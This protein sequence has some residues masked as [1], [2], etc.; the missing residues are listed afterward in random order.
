MS[1]LAFQIFRFYLRYII[2]PPA[3]SGTPNPSNVLTAVNFLSEG[4]APFTYEYQWIRSG[5][6][7]AG[8][9]SSTYTVTNQDSLNE[10]RVGVRSIDAQGRKSFWGYSDPVSV[11]VVGPTYSVQPTFDNPTYTQ[12]S[13]ITVTTG[14]AGPSATISISK[15]SLNGV[16]KRSE[17]VFVNSTTYTWNSTGAPAG[18]INYQ[19]TATNT[20]GVKTSNDL[21]SALQVPPVLTPS[22]FVIGNWALTNEGS[23]GKA[24]ITITTQPSNGGSAITNTEYRIG[25]GAWIPSGVTTVGD[26]IIS[27]FTNA[28]ATDVTIRLVNSAG[29]GP[30]SDIKTVTTSD[31]LSPTITSLIYD[32]PT[33]SATV[34]T[35][36]TAKKYY[37]VN[38]SPTTLTGAAIKTQ[39]LAS[40]PIA[41]GQ[42]NIGVTEVIPNF[43]SMVAGAY[44]LHITSEDAAGNVQTSSSKLS[45]DWPGVA[46]TVSPILSLATSA[47]NGV[48]AAIGSVS[49]TKATGTLRWIVSLS[50]TQPTIT[51]IEAGQ[52]NLGA[53][54]IAAG[55]QAVNATGVQNISVTGL[56]AS[57]TYFIHYFHRD[58]SS[59]ASNLITSPSFTTAAATGDVEV[60]TSTLMISTTS[61]G[62]TYNSTSDHTVSSSANRVVYAFIRGYLDT[63]GVAPTIGACNFGGVAMTPIVASQGSGARDWIAVYEIKNP[64]SG[65]KNLDLTVSVNQRAMSVRAVEVKNVDQTTS[66]DAS[67]VAINT[68]LLTTK[69]FTRTTTRAGNLLLSG[70]CIDGGNLAAEVTVS[71]DATSIAIEQT[72]TAGT[73]DNT[74]ALAYE[75]APAAGSNGHSYSWISTKRV[76]LAWLDIRKA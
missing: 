49:T 28:V 33:N 34:A 16:D 2:S 12:G 20:A 46:D 39:V 50:A 32:T 43:T 72:G 1:L 75:L 66:T 25:A 15:F 69:S 64:S 54:A 61:S 29:N 68:S 6:N 3:I 40:S 44:V 10:V 37:L 63:S 57:T 58:V 27:G 17:L 30:A 67:G 65:N 51:Q 7:I 45:F 55:S 76:S 59:N 62:L 42:M 74:T 36:E 23:G 19:T 70:I 73:S 8:A 52:N 14:V 31:T 71:S 4:S 13:I 53:A 11:D 9:T 38:T 56:T 48:S 41:F 22:A 18:A 47:A 35:S 60:V 21:T 5:V 26:I 24:K